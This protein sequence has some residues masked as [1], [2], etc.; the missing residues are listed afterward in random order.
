MV[1]VSCFKNM[2]IIINTYKMY[3]KRVINGLKLMLTKTYKF[4]DN[5]LKFFIINYC[6]LFLCFQSIINER[7]DPQLTFFCL[8]VLL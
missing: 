8:K 5:E 6:K 7:I 3:Q 1:V 2:T 4:Y